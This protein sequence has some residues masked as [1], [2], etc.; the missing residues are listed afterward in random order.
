V[1]LDLY[2][3][4]SS[5]TGR[6]STQQQIVTDYID[7]SSNKQDFY[8]TRRV[9]AVIDYVFRFARHERHRNAKFPALTAKLSEG[10]SPA[11]TGTSGT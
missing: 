9:G 2:F 4:S 10:S 5:K 1:Y 8:G 11:P 3:A 6:Q 7:P